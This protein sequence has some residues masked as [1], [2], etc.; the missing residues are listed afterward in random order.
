M[1]NIS[2]YLIEGSKDSTIE[3]TDHEKL[4]TWIHNKIKEEELIFSNTK[5]NKLFTYEK[6]NTWEFKTGDNLRTS[7]DDN[8]RFKLLIRKLSSYKLASFKRNNKISNFRKQ[9]NRKKRNDYMKKNKI[10]LIEFF[11]RYRL[12][13]N[14]KDLDMLSEET[15][16]ERI[17]KYCEM[18]HNVE[19]NMYSTLKRFVN[20][21]HQQR[22]NR[23]YF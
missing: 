1:L 9:I 20:S 16:L 12:Q 4:I 11:Y 5:F 10:S 8:T 17:F 6:I 2:K 22:C 21:L 3:R 15:D 23:N 14:Y 7:I 13:S 18:Y 19:Q